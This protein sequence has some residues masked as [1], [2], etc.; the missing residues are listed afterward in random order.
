MRVEG[1][2]DTVTQATR[3]LLDGFPIV[4]NYLKATATARA[5]RQANQLQQPTAV[6]DK[7][8]DLS[9]ALGYAHGEQQMFSQVTLGDPIC[10]SLFHSS[11]ST[12]RSTK[13][14]YGSAR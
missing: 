2:D 12:V 3:R 9:V 13:T 7:P 11:D 10:A 6:N 1:T 8:A 4:L 5:I 14:L